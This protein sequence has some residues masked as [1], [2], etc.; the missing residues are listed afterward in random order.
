MPLSSKSVTALRAVSN[1]LTLP[2][3]YHAMNHLPS[4]VRGCLELEP[5]NPNFKKNL[6]IARKRVEETGQDG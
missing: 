4:L 6:D 2:S 3:L 5:E 1:T